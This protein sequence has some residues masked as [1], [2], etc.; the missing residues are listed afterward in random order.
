M[1]SFN[2]KYGEYSDYVDGGNEVTIVGPQGE[3]SKRS[4]Q[5]SSFRTVDELIEDE[6]EVK[7]EKFKREW[8]REDK[9]SSEWFSD[10][11]PSTWNPPSRHLTEETFKNFKRIRKRESF[12][13][14]ITSY[15]IILALLGPGGE[16]NWLICLP[17]NTPEYCEFIRDRI[18]DTETAKR[19]IP[20]MREEEKKRLV[21]TSTEDVINDFYVED[22]SIQKK[23]LKKIE[24]RCEKNIQRY[25]ELLE[26]TYTKV[27]D[28]WEF[29]KGRKTPTETEE[30][31]AK[32]ECREEVGVND[33]LIKIVTEVEPLTETYTG[34][35]NNLYKSVFFLAVAKKADIASS[36][37]KPKRS[38]LR[39]YITEEVSTVKIDHLTEVS[40]FIDPKKIDMLVSSS[41][42]LKK[43]MDLIKE[44][45]LT[46]SFEEFRE[47]YD[48]NE[49]GID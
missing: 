30:E 6:E 47:P 35:D 31:C 48:D 14:P 8:R 19:Y 28:K 18:S 37:P 10:Y 9:R 12:S 38:V 29:P 41:I 34:S 20:N 17:R 15:G 21:R 42:W 45:Y 11:R 26:K 3:F 13:K 1:F 32:R 22:R 4:L 44:K 2:E 24:K 43:N 49:L 36:I 46:P 39:E 23:E 27:R 5:G 33:K 40:K 25:K 16:M 7:E